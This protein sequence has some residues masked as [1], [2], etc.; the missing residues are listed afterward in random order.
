[1][2]FRDGDNIVWRNMAFSQTNTRPVKLLSPPK[3]L[4]VIKK[5]PLGKLHKQEEKMKKKF[6]IAFYLFAERQDIELIYF[7]LES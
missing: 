5:K 7:R 4:V 6:N 3:T 1:M 2:V